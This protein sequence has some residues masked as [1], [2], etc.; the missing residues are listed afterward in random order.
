MDAQI[1][2]RH[3]ESIAQLGERDAI[4]CRQDRDDGEAAPLVEHGIEFFNNMFQ[5][6]HG[7]NSQ[8]VVSSHRLVEM[9]GIFP[10][11]DYE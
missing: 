5:C 7:H 10:T 2:I 3:F 4:E 9:N 8:N 6:F 1:S 11:F